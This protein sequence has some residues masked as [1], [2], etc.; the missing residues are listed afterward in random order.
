MSK[1]FLILI[2]PLWL[3]AWDVYKEKD[4]IT[5]YKEHDEKFEFSQYKAITTFN[6][7]LK[8]ISD[9]IMN[10]HSYTSWLSDCIK[11]DKKEDKV[12]ILMSPPWPLN[13]RQVWA[14]IEKKVYKDKAIITLNSIDNKNSDESGVWFKYLH[15]EFVLTP[16]SQNATQ[17]SL[18]LFGNPGGFPPAWMVNWLAWEIPYQSLFDLNHYLKSHNTV[19]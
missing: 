13:N 19:E 11:A 10:H 2:L 5:I 4:N 7:S 6:F 1:L 14:Q 3:F 12:Y 17:V 18:S 9:A 15:A 16:L 8:K